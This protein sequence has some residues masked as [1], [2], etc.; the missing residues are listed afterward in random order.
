MKEKI[1]RLSEFLIFICLPIHTFAADNAQSTALKAP[2]VLPYNP[3]TQAQIRLYGKNGQKI[4][5]QHS[6][7][8]DAKEKGIRDYVSNTGGWDAFKTYTRLNFNRSE[9]MPK[10]AIQQIALTNEFQTYLYISYKEFL[11]T[12]NEPINLHGFV[13]T[14]ENSARTQAK[15]TTQCENAVASFKPQAGHAYEVLGQYQQG[16]CSFKIYDL[17][18]NQLVPHNDQAYVCPKKKSWSLF[19]K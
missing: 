4:Y 7:V 6:F 9:G 14:A 16:Q 15:V 5:L 10:T 13:M 2:E 1:K 3:L 12:A 11:V 18:T 19:G 17:Q 8:C